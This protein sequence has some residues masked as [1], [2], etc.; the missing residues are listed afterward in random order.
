MPQTP[1][2]KSCEV[3]VE[4][5]TTAI[6][7]KFFFRDALEVFKFLFGNPVYANHLDLIPTQIWEGEGEDIQ[8]FEGPMTGQFAWEIQ[9][10]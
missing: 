5:G 2:W 9:V 3:N 1:A 10:M 8:I 7:I 4:G 6:P